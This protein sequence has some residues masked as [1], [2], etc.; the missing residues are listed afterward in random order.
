M[1]RNVFLVD[2]E[3]VNRLAFTGVTA[4]TETDEVIVLYTKACIKTPKALEDFYLKT[5]ASLTMMYAEN[6]HK[7]A[8]D[9]QLSALLGRLS[10]EERFKTKYYIIAK[11]KGYDCL[12]I[13]LSRFGIDVIR[14]ESI[15]AAITGMEDPIATAEVE[16]EEDEGTEELSSY[17]MA[18]L[19]ED[20]EDED[21]ELETLEKKA[22]KKKKDKKKKKEEKEKEAE[23]PVEEK[24]KKAGKGGSLV[25]VGMPRP[26]GEDATL[27]PVDVDPAASQAQPEV[28]KAAEPT[29][30]TSGKTLSPDL[31]LV[32]QAIKER[33]CGPYLIYQEVAIEA[34]LYAKAHPEE[35]KNL[36][37]VAHR[38][39]TQALRIS[40]KVKKVYNLLKPFLK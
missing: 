26:W 6:G 25:L 11:D 12:S 17:E 22:K 38:Y 35:G 39:L 13:F 16:A 21:A 10:C 14:R 18:P 37:E 28:A 2:F 23:K 33:F 4:L 30:D 29:K 20:A 3:N 7:N 15:Y 27:L 1:D 34:Y 9:F 8:L 36:M 32:V 24:K 40:T 19:P 5:K 31:A